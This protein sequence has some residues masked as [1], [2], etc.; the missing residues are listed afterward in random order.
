[1]A[2]GG[3]RM[4]DGVGGD[5]REINGQHSGMRLAGVVRNRGSNEQCI[6]QRAAGDVWSRDR[7]S[8]DLGVFGMLYSVLLLA[9]V[10]VFAV[11]LT[12]LH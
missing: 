3:W 9:V 5:D 1:M 6:V 8:L 12:D 10:T 4:A 11:L 2:D 7:R